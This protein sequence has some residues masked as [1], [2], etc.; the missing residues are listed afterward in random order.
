VNGSIVTAR[1]PMTPNTAD[2]RLRGTVTTLL[3]ILLAVMI[4]RDIL[5]RRW[6]GPAAAHGVTYRSS[7]DSERLRRPRTSSEA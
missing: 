3:L 4:V 1:K 2:S 7:C 5:A 6:A